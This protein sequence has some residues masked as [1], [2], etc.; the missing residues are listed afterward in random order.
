MPTRPRRKSGTDKQH[1][2]K[3]ITEM[4]EHCQNSVVVAVVMECFFFSVM[5][6]ITTNKVYTNRLTIKGIRLIF[7]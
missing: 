2:L 3:H 7:F 6:D 5:F 1:S 4:W